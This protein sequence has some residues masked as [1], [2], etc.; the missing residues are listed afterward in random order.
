MMRTIVKANKN[1]IANTL[2]WEVKYHII[3]FD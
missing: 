1:A 2:E 3:R